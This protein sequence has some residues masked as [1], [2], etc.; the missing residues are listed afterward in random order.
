MNHL[1][2]GSG[3]LPSF[4]HSKLTV[5]TVVLLAAFG[6]G[7]PQI[8]ADN[9]GIS[10]DNTCKTM[11]KNNVTSDCPT[12]EDIITIFPDTSIKGVSGEFGYRDGIYQRL[13]TKFTDSFEYYRFWDRPILFVDPPVET[14]TRIKLIEIKANLDTY[15]IR[16]KNPSYNQQDH[17][18]TL[19]VGRYIDSCR[20]AYVAADD[21]ISLVGDTM[22]HMANNCSADSTKFNSTITTKLDKVEHDITTSYKY[23]L[24]LW[25]KEMVLKCGKKVCLYERN[26]T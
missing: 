18:M 2:C 13:P 16:G 7:L 8:Y 20:V 3:F 1:I 21:W 6:V 15:L 17:S 19:G 11:I 25:Q 4:S 5:L 22:Y 24:E 23:K 9:F 14:A 10:Y 26:Q 12:Y